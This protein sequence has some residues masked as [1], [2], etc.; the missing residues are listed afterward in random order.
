MA[1]SPETV[2]EFAMGDYTYVVMS[3]PLPGRDAE[4]NEWYTHQHLAAVMA[5]PGFISARRF[6]LVDATAEG[7]PKQ[8]YLALYNMRTDTPETVLA[9]L[10]ELVESGKMH[11]SEAMNINDTVTTLYRS[12]SEEVR[13]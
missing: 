12:I 3:N 8:R 9:A 1:L 7:A 10:V 5:V 11:I 6:V 4:Y 13:A 2:V